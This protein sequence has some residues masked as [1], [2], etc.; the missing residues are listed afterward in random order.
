M[1]LKG[2]EVPEL[3]EK[4]AYDIKNPPLGRAFL[5]IVLLVIIEQNLLS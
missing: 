5:G 1:G 4:Y 2:L 3:K